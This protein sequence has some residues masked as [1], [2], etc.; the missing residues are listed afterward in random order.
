MEGI[1]HLMQASTYCEDMKKDGV[2]LLKNVI[3]L[4]HIQSLINEINHI[5]N[6]VMSKISK[7][8]RPLKTYS[9]IAERQL[10]R[11]D[12]RCG[13]HSAIFNEVGASIMELVKH[14]SPTI[15]FRPYWGAI[16]S[17]SGSGPTDM[18]RDIY[19]IQNTAKDNDLDDYDVNLPPYYLTV[20]MPLDQ[21]TLENGPTEFIKGSH[22]KKVVDELHAEIYAP[23][24]SP[25]DIIIF[26]GRTL[27]KGTPNH[28][29]REKLIAYITFVANWYHDQ[30]FSINNYLFPE[31]ASPNP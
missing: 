20:F 10:N 1:T 14:I 5:R 13:F 11:L 19:Q 21:I 2:I 12:Y 7:M 18:H 4:P 30:T 26:D 16:P 3:S 31:L 23:L 28:S 27:H 22:K 29:S 15:D 24:P 25:G 8:D 17:L 9:D 6:Y